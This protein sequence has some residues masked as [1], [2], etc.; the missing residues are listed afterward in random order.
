MICSSANAHNARHFPSSE[1][2][3]QLLA[4]GLNGEDVDLD[5]IGSE[6]DVRHSYDQVLRTGMMGILMLCVLLAFF[7]GLSDF[8][9]R[10]NL[11]P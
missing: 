2:A 6:I 4:D 11:F 3:N 10:S 1:A 5:Y 9:S 7:V 8:D